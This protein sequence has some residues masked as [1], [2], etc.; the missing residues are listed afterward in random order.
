MGVLEY[1]QLPLLGVIRGALGVVIGEDI[2]P[3]GVPIAIK[4]RRFTWNS[5]EWFR[6]IRRDRGGTK[7]WQ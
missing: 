1:V 2:H 3:E 7:R 5:N 4:P 6:S